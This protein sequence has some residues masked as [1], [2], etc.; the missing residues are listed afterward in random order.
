LRHRSAFRPHR[1][2]RW[3]DVGQIGPGARDGENASVLLLFDIDGTLLLRASE[4]H[5]RAL[6][7]ALRSVYGL[8]DASI[9][10]VA[11]AGR[12]DTQ[13][14]RA[15][16][17]ACGLDRESFDELLPQFQAACAEAFAHSCP[18]SLAS[19]LGPGIRELLDTLSDRADTRLSLL[20]GN[21]EP[22]ARLKLARAGI[23]E[24]FA[25]GQGAFGSDAELRDYLGPIA[26]A[27]AGSD[28]IPY[29]RKRTTVIGDTPLDIACARADGLRVIAIATGPYSA[30]D[31][32]SADHVV[33]NA[34][35]LRALLGSG[36]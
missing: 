19:H 23:A 12:T 9:H 11:A 25:A 1:A 21:Y 7:D 16:A 33:H 18:P 13:I 22:V 27:R 14:A 6:L 20:T 36:E 10:R 15:I 2:V 35:E 3:T 26:R 31:L 30:A 29:P 4:P 34:Y 32:S 5:R 28:G 17:L 24:H 8:T